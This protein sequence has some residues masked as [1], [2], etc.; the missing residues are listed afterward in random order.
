ML[1]LILDNCQGSPDFHKPVT[2]ACSCIPQPH[3]SRIALPAGIAESRKV[4]IKDDLFKRLCLGPV[5]LKE[6][7]TGLDER[8][9]LF[10]DRANQLTTRITEI[11]EPLRS[12]GIEASHKRTSTWRGWII[13]LSKYQLSDQGRRD[14]AVQQ[15]MD[16]ATRVVELEKAREKRDRKR[17]KLGLGSPLFEEKE[18]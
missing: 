15:E 13:D 16:Y 18:V 17:S 8:D 6:A 3:L 1:G 5:D 12:V 11:L 10:P 7:D 2:Y 14:D 4:A 9:K